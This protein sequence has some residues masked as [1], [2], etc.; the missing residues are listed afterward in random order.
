[1]ILGMGFFDSRSLALATS[2]RT[3]T[4]GECEFLSSPLRASFCCK[5]LRR[6]LIKILKD[7]P[8]TG[9]LHRF[10]GGNDLHFLTFSCYKRQPFL[11]KE[12]HADL[13]LQIV[14]RVRRRYRL[15]VLGYVVMPEHVHFL[16]SERREQNSQR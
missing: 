10:Y 13:F 12:A 14:E 1:M 5:R 9:N 16:V 3:T 11:N 6:L 7:V 15:V 8:F 2:L 4:V